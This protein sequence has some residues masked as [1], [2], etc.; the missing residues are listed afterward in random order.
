VV[1]YRFDRQ[2][3]EG[4]VNPG[5]FLLDKG[6]ELITLDGNLQVMPYTEMKALCFISESGLTDLFRE[7]NLFERR[8]KVAGLWTRFMFR[9][10]DRL[11][12]ILSHN[13]LDWPPPGYFITPPRAG[14]TRQRVFLP[15][16]ALVGTE[17]RGVVGRSLVAARQRTR[18]GAPDQGDQLTMFDS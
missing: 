16:A 13:L 8:P 3:L 7:H 5:A 17:L 12:G 2:P 1:L 9:D 11:D 18:K 4:I 14:P 15:R 10:G 6:V